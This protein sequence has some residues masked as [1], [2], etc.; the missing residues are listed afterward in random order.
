MNIEFLSYINAKYGRQYP[1]H[2][3]F[4]WSTDVVNYGRLSQRNQRYSQPVRHWFINYQ[5][6]TL[7]DRNRL[8]EIFNRAAGQYRT[9]KILETGQDGDYE[10]SLAE[11][12]ITAVAAQTQF[13]LVK[14]YYDGQTEEWT[15][16]KKKIVPGTIF[17]PVIKLNSTIKTE[18]T[19]YTLDDETGIV[20][21]GSAP[22]AAVVMT[23]NYRFY[24]SI[25][26]GADVYDDI[27]NL[28]EHWQAENIHLIE[29]E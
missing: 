15:E 27:R 20:T 21:F 2:R 14:T 22:G 9:F 5:G 18:G 3:Q 6:L 23:A 12:S 1:A 10:C 17:P 7:D 26:F 29:D 13:Q 19:D 11:C 16:N 24:F 28:P 4:Q 25:R 8:L